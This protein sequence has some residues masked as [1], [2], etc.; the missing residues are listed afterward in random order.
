MKRKDIGTHACGSVGACKANDGVERCINHYALMDIVCYVE[1]AKV[2]QSVR[3]PHG[4]PIV[5]VEG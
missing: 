3:L 2:L 4:P 5:S 1:G